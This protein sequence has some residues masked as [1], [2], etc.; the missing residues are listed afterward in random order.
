MITPLNRRFLL[1]ERPA[2]DFDPKILERVVEPVPRPGPGQ[3]LVRNLYLSL[4]PTNRVW[5]G[6]RASYLPPVPLG[7]VMRGV[8]VGRVIASNTPRY[9]VAT[10]VLGM[11]GWQD[12]ALV[13]DRD[14][15]PVQTLPRFLP[16]PLTATLG[17]LGVTGMT[18]YFGLLEVGQPGRGE[19]VVISAAAGAVG[20]IAGQIAKLRGARVV[21]IAGTREKCDW[22]T[23]ELGFDAA[24]CRRDADWRAQLQAA[25][26]KGVDV[27]FE[28]AGGEIMEA[29]LDLMNRHGRVVLCG[30]ISQ[31]GNDDRGMAGPRN[32]ANLLTRRIRLQGFIILDYIPRFPL[33]Q[34][35]MLWWMKRGRVRDRY[36]VVRGLDQ[37]PRALVQLFNGENFGKLIVEIDEP[38]APTAR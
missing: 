11:L 5:M 35:R 8:A 32:F 34:L 24:V 29:V 23:R 28:N 9:R 1:R 37:A 4:D 38:N 14:E 31:Y 21:G 33:A 17:A 15:F 3:A 26:P 30:M 20:S 18:A 10:N 19:T 13:S 6:E 12:Y 2:G 22:L 25:C 36:T 7:G 16:A 27:D